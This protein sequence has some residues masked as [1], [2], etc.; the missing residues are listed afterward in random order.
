MRSFSFS[1]YCWYSKI[2]RYCRG[3]TASNVRSADRTYA[4]IRDL[5]IFA[6]AVA[7]AQGALSESVAE[8]FT[9]L[10]GAFESLESDVELFRSRLDNLSDIQVTLA[11]NKEK[12]FYIRQL[13]RKDLLKMVMLLV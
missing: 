9:N 12:Y 5:K 1:S 7:S 13:L 4:K 11:E 10:E 8:S 3:C 2:A 6:T